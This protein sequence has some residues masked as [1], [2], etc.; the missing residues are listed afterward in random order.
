ME[1]ATKNS[2][3]S[4]SFLIF[5]EHLKI[6]KHIFFGTWFQALKPEF[7][8]VVVYARVMATNS[9]REK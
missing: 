2:F 1:T 9:I 4:Y 5:Q 8:L 3:K 7:G 6:P